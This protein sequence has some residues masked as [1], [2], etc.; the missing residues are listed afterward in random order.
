MEIRCEDDGF[1]FSEV[2]MEW[3]FEFFFIIKDVGLGTGLG[4][5]IC[6]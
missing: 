3:A 5:V 1:G 2:V 6:Q 4:L